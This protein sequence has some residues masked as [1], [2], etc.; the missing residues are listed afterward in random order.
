[1]EKIQYDSSYKFLVLIGT[2]LVVTPTVGLYYLLS[3]S[4]DIL[5][6]NQDFHDLSDLSSK[7]IMIKAEWLSVLFEILPYAFIALFI[8]GIVFIIYGCSKWNKIQKALDELTS[9][10]LQEK[11]LNIQKMTVPVIVEKVMKDDAEVQKET[12]YSSD[13]DDNIEKESYESNSSR[14]LK[15]IQIEEAC[16]KY[17][18]SKI[19][20]KYTVH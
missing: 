12:F 16:Y 3:G 15:A 13:K 10:D 19:H 5:I 7:L 6:S 17:A 8:V 1:M 2:V 18:K 9:L 4:F 20:K 14:M 11:R